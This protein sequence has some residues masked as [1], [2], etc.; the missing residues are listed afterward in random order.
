[1]RENQQNT[2]FSWLICSDTEHDGYG[3]AEPSGVPIFRSIGLGSCGVSGG[4]EGVPDA[5][6]AEAF[7]ILYVGGGELGDAVVAQREREA[8]I[9]NAAAGELRGG[10]R[11]QTSA[12]RL[13]G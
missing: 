1:M 5:G 11:G 2:P 10:G 13:P 7:E 12:I 9:V 3:F 4:G 6:E 8:G